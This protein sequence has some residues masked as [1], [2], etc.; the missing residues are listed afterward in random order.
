MPIKIYRK[1][2]N[3]PNGGIFTSYLEDNIKEG[4]TILCQ[5]IK[6]KLKYNGLGEFEVVGKKVNKKR[7]VGFIVG[8]T[9]ITPMFS[10]ALA[11]TMAYDG[12]EITFLCSNKTKEDMLLANQLDNLSK[13]N[14]NLKVFHTLTR[15]NEENDG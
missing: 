2:E 8:G 1:T 7:R 13:I 3:F 5:E 14:S 10:I 12:L 6:S 15:H 4:D 11:S 9:G